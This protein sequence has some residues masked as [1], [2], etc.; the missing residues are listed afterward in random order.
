MRS[1]VMIL[2]ICGLICS[3]GR[4]E[5]LHAQAL[6]NGRNA[7][8]GRIVHAESGEPL[9]SVHVFLSGTTIGTVTN[10]SGRFRIGRVPSGAHRLTVS[11]IGF[12]RVTDNLMVR[13]GE[14]R[15]V[16]VK[17][18]PIVYE[19]DPLFVGNL[20]DEWQEDLERFERLFLGESPLADSVEILNPEV[21]RFEKNWWGRFTAKALAPLEIE[22]HALGYHVTYFLD[23]FQ[24]TG[25]RTR[26]DGEPLFRELTPKDSL[27]ASRWKENRKEAFYGSLRHFLLTLIHDRLQEEGF[28]LYRY[29]H[30]PT[31]FSARRRYRE[32]R[33]RLI[34]Q[35]EEDPVF[36][37]NF[38]GRLEV[39]FTGAE[40]D[41]HYI[42]WLRTR[43]RAPANSQISYLE[44]NE[45][46]ITVDPDGE[47]LETYGATRFGYFSYKRIADITPRQ[48]R[49][50]DIDFE[51]QLSL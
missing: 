31:G 5:P 18:K 33:R 21:L 36:K 46:P 15:T 51:G 7:I 47:I 50:E 20:D 19:M 8:E 48:Y 32:F 22:N 6:D 30:N 34:T 27:Q 44:L 23:E 2:L 10:E 17:L 39:R 37:L 9:R 13:A 38:F 14:T 40:E 49:P 3:A 12:K 16:Y 4:V 45:Q 11:I 41:E 28:I 43:N 29:P 42:R 35:D 26:W 25:T 1:F 24:H